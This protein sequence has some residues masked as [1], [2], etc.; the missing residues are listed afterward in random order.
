[1]GLQVLLV[2]MLRQQTIEPPQYSA[3]CGVVAALGDALATMERIVNT[4]MPMPYLVHLRQVII[5]FLILLPLQVGAKLGYWCIPIV[6]LT[7][8]TYEGIDTIGKEVED[9]FGEDHNDLPI[10][11]YCLQIKAELDRFMP[12][13][14]YGDDDD[15]D[16]DDDEES[17]VGVRSSGDG[18][19][20]VFKHVRKYTDAFDAHMAHEPRYERELENRLI[21][22]T[23]A[24]V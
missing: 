6:G 18:N 10:D 22:Y 3:L 23:N 16:N 20:E 4:P 14:G 13:N 21:E 15:V 19:A 24:V 9:P 17:R 11:G 1:V 5:L 7:V 2:D 8:F 12:D